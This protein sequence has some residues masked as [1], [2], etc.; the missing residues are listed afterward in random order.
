[1]IKRTVLLVNTELSKLTRLRM[2]VVT[3]RVHTVWMIFADDQRTGDNRAGHNFWCAHHWCRVEKITARLCAQYIEFAWRMQ[4]VTV[5]SAK[6]AMRK[7]GTRDAG[8]MKL[9][10]NAGAVGKEFT[11][12]LA[13]ENHQRLHF[14]DW[15]KT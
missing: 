9:A 1:M 4:E 12:L 7:S 15:T 5:V 10:R 13:F 11:P 3:H 8:M 14:C 6:C 2:V